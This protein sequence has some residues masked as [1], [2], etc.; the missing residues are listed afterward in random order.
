MGIAVNDA[1]IAACAR[2]GTA[3]SAV[4]QWRRG[5]RIGAALAEAR[6]QAGLTVTEVSQRTR[7]RETV[8][9]GIEGDDYSACGGD[10]YAR[11]DIRSIARAVGTDPEPLIREYDLIHRAPGVLSAVSLNELLSPAQA[12]RRRRVNWAVALGLT[13]AVAL[14][15]VGYKFL[16]GSPHRA[17]TPLAD[18][19]RA[20]THA[21]PGGPAPAAKIS[22]IA[23]RDAPVVVVHLTAIRR[24]SVLFT[25]S[26]GR[27]LIR[28][29]VAAGAS[30]TWAFRQAVHLRLDHPGGVTLTV[31]GANPLPS[32]PAARP[33]TLILRP[34]H[35][36]T[37]ATR[38]PMG[39]AATVRAYLAAINGRH[40]ARAWRLGGRN[41]GGSYAGFVSG[42]S[43]TAKDTVT[44]VSVSGDVATAR[45]TARQTDGTIN[46]YQGTYTVQHGVIT[47]FDVLQV[48]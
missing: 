23:A 38:T 10:F 17:A 3:G 6:D 14:G 21:G 43:T 26:S 22:Q 46:T 5:V 24:C 40:Y 34:G 9:R 2:D 39:P 47:G 28:S 48:S 12:P 20:V 33:V 13:L 41:T 11:G 30:N 25:T 27:H 36:A 15:F 19:S 35:P 4:E 44:V 16:A 45:L 32:R 18:A 8:I 29:H 42:F 1:V 7:I 37:V 31:D